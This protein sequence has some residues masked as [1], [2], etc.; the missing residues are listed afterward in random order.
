MKSDKVRDPQE[1][2]KM[3]QILY[4]NMREN[5]DKEDN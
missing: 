2:K 3:K 1:I 4:N 5:G